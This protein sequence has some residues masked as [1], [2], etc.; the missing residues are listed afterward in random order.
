MNV[1]VQSIAGEGKLGEV[2]FVVVFGTFTQKKLAI[3]AN[4][5]YDKEEE[6]ELIEGFYDKC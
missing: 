3:Q 4:C 5:L 2:S 6:Y 1:S